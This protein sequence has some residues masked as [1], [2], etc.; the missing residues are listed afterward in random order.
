MRFVK[1]CVVKI[2]LCLQLSMDAANFMCFSSNLDKIRFRK[3][4]QNCSVSFNL[5]ISEVKAVVYFVA[6]VNFN[7]FFPHCCPIWVIFGISDLHTVLLIICELHADRH[8]EGRT[9]I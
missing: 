6:Q 1:S 8:R 4:A 7:S 2:T 9:F 3:R 5:K